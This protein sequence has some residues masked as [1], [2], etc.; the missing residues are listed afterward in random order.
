MNL[1]ALL[2]FALFL[3][4][5][6]A[7]DS[8]IYMSYCHIIKKGNNALIT[9]SSGGTG[10]FL[11][12]ACNLNCT[13]EREPTIIHFKYAEMMSLGSFNIVDDYFTIC[14]KMPCFISDTTQQ[15]FYD[16]YLKKFPTVTPGSSP[17][18]STNPQPGLPGSPSYQNNA[19]LPPSTNRWTDFS[20]PTQTPIPP[21]P[22]PPPTGKSRP[23]HKNAVLYKRNLDAEEGQGVGFLQ[24]DYMCDNTNT[25]V[26]TSSSSSKTT[27]DFFTTK[28]IIIIS[29][30]GLGAIILFSVIYCY[31]SARSNANIEKKRQ[32]KLDK[33][34]EKYK[35]TFDFKFDENGSIILEIENIEN[36]FKDKGMSV[37]VSAPIENL[38]NAIDQCVITIEDK[39]NLDLEKVE[40]IK[41]IK[42]IEEKIEEIKEISIPQIQQIQIRPRL[43]QRQ[44]TTRR[45]IPRPNGANN[46]GGSRRRRSNHPIV[47]NVF[48]SVIRGG[49]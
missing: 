1:Y 23:A 33:I 44:G 22:P 2:I 8:I 43:I 6:Y 34:N 32:E 40:E 46:R 36:Y 38:I 5:N 30:S 45:N 21:P 35:K 7:T 15:S 27:A 24:T 11:G 37:S 14:D 4:K 41:E 28:I 42:E 9:P 26:I 49:R 10:A 16:T 48:G 39:S 13:S 31:C 20:P 29:F 19:P 25:T 12:H 17:P 18:P 47:G 3:V